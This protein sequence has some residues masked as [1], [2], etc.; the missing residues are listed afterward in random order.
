MSD[1]LAGNE[2]YIALGD[3]FNSLRADIENKPAAEMEKVVNDFAN[4]IGSI[5]GASKIKSAMS[6][7]RR[8]LK[9]RTPKLEAALKEFDKAKGLYEEQ[10]D[11]RAKAATDLAAGV[12][13][14]ELALRDTIGMRQQPRVTREQGLAIASCQSGHRDI[15]LN[16]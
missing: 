16:F 8:N 2:A 4:R 9:R 3:E 6:K 1:T 11:W 13:T 7:V 15:S 10:L 12:S 14:Y 5:D